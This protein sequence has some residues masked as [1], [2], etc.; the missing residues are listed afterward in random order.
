MQ[1]LM[2][3]FDITPT[4]FQITSTAEVQS[5]LWVGRVDQIEV[6]KVI[7]FQ[8]S[9]VFFSTTVTIKNVGTSTVSNLYCKLL[10]LSVLPHL[11]FRYEDCRP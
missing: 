8:N 3:K 7:Y 9:D 4:T 2:G 5:V 10:Y 6:T 11:L 1:G